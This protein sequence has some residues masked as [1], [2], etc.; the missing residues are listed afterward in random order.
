MTLGDDND[1]IR[2]RED[3]A[4]FVKAV[5]RDLRDNPTSWSNTSLQ[6]Y[7][8]ALAAWVDDMDGYYSNRG[9]LIPEQPDWPIV[10]DMLMAARVY[11]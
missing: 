10:A 9:R 8:E 4:E 1:T 6:S 2:T 3:F 5:S 7:L 11:E